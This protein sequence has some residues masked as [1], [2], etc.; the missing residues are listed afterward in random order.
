MKLKLTVGLAAG[1]LVAATGA[2][3][4]YFAETTGATYLHTGPGAAY[5]L[6]TPMPAGAKV[7]VQR[8]SG[9]WCRVVWTQYAGY[10]PAAL[11]A[12][13]GAPYPVAPPPPPAADTD[14]LDCGPYYDPTCAGYYDGGYIYPYGVY[15]GGHRH[16][17][18]HHHWSGV[19][20]P[21]ANPGHGSFG[22]FSHP[23][24]FGGAAHSGGFGGG[25]IWRH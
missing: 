22:G 24:G 20:G 17:G 12:S 23:G 2:A 15:G 14:L 10:M 25:G 7:N 1:V 13:A 11:L 18:Q 16:Y 4:A 5:S 8:C 6:V 21:P 9:A 3:S 19:G